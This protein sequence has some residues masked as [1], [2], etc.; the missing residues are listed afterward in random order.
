MSKK[1]KAEL[2]ALQ[3]AS[4]DKMLH[5]ESVVSWARTHPRSALHRQF[6][7]NNGKA[8]ARYRLW[9]ARQLIQINVITEDGTP[10]LVS[11]SFDRVKGGGYRDVGDVV[12][13]RKLSEI[14]LQD[15]LAELQRVQARFQRVRELTSVWTAVRRVRQRNAA[16]TLKKAA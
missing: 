8:A 15:A 10:Q 5:A 7:W 9:Q 14:M 4:K 11:L 3:R 12:N 1:V 6:E 2:L 13:S 16:R